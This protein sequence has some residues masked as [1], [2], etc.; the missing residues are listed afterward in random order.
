[1][2]KSSRQTPQDARV[3]S[4]YREIDS[5][6][7][8]NQRLIDTAID[9][10]AKFVGGACYVSWGKDS[11]AMLHLLCV[12]GNMAPVV[13]WRIPELDNP[14]CCAVRDAFLS[15]YDVPYYEREYDFSSVVKKEK[16]WK[17]LQQE[18][19]ANRLVGIRADESKTRRLSA[20]VHGTSGRM[21][22]RPLLYWRSAD[23][24]AY[25][26]RTDLPLNACY[27]F[28]G[29]GRWKR[30]NIRTHCLYGKIAQRNGRGSGMGKTEW[31]KEYFTPELR[32]IS[33]YEHF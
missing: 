27:G 16:H 15:R 30:E 17:L 32:R 20:I 18:F 10:C 23:V 33:Q 14:E 2:I 28:L 1:M 9:T 3:Y 5:I 26:E 7:Q 13:W 19:G 8:I 24:F 6:H 22:W 12:S 4:Q 21:S 25:I 29:G 11:V 31:E